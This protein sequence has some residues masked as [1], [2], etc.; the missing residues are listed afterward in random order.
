MLPIQN[1]WKAEEFV[2]SDAQFLVDSRFG[3]HKIVAQIEHR[4]QR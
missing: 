3:E 2:L 1:V 4:M